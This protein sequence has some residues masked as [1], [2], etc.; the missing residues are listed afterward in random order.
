MSK[1]NQRSY[2]GI[3]FGIA[4]AYIVPFA[5]GMS[6]AYLISTLVLA[7]VSGGYTF[8]YTPQ[9]NTADLG[10][11]PQDDI[12]SYAQEVLDSNIFDVEVG[13][14]VV[15]VDEP[16][17]VPTS[18][19]TLVGLIYNPGK[20]FAFV[21]DGNDVFFV[22]STR[23]NT[24]IS[25]MIQSATQIGIVLDCDGKSEALELAENSRKATTTST[26][27]TTTASRRPSG[28]VSKVVGDSPVPS[29]GA[30]ISPTAGGVNV[31]ISRDY[32]NKQLSDVNKIFTTTRIAPKYSNDEFLGYSILGFSTDSPLKA[33]GIQKGD[34]IVRINGASTD[35][36]TALYGLVGDADGIDSLTIEVLRGGAKR[37]IF[38]NVSE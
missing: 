36:P 12:A 6:V 24:Q 17:A 19:Y 1:G 30:K 37:T 11:M 13:I 4:H 20:S 28:K 5:I 10:G 16:A 32:V 7:S 9:Q 25:C 3:G 18:S 22:S 2:I 26:T 38:V 29:S 33:I 15:A 8:T 34:V 23:I 31:E 35:N 14:P 27:T 21:K